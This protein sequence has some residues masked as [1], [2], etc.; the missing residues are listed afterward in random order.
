MK[1]LKSLISFFIIIIFLVSLASVVSA[2]Q[3]VIYHN[4]EIDTINHMKE[5]AKDRQYTFVIED[6]Q[7]QINALEQQMH[8]NNIEDNDDEDDDD[9]FYDCRRKIRKYI[10]GDDD[11]DDLDDYLDDHDRCED[12]YYDDY[13]DN[14]DWDNNW[15]HDDDWYDH[16]DDRYDD[17]YENCKLRPSD[18]YDNYDYSD[19]L[20]DMHWRGKCKRFWDNHRWYDYDT[21]IDRYENIDTSIDPLMNHYTWEHYYSK[22][23]WY[24]D[25]LE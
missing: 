5:N 21:F 8:E 17:W 1:S 23:P 25:K 22:Y 7:S 14:D 12:Y 4:D 2:K 16:Y 18:Y 3:Y 9:D 10:N 15:L 24:D 19:Y 11:W 6:M 13:W 20:K